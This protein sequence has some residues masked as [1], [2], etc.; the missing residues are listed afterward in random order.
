MK[1]AEIISERQRL[2]EAAPLAFLAPYLPAALAW[3][4][5]ASW[6]AIIGWGL[7]AWSTAETVLKIKGI[8]E[9]EGTDPTKWSPETQYDVASDIAATAVAAALGPAWKAAKGMYDKVWKTTPDNIKKEVFNK[10]VPEIEKVIAK[11]GVKP[12]DPNLIDR[13][14]SKEVPSTAAPSANPAAKDPNKI[15]R[16][17]KI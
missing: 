15:E 16:P 2:N 14:Y 6:L 13:P 11:T 8:V 5:T 3:I 9:A 7:A 1:V 4:A 12:K 10:S 17:F